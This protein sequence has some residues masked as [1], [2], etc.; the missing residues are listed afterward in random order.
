MPILIIIFIAGLILTLVIVIIQS[1]RTTSHIIDECGSDVDCP[2]GD[3]CLSNPEEQG[4]KQCFPSGK[5]FCVIDPPTQLKKCECSEVDENGNCVNGLA[6]CESCLNNPAFSCIQV[7]DKNPYT[8]IQGN[9]QVSIPNSATGYGWCLPNVVNRTVECNPFTS[10][11]ILAE[12]A[13]GQ[14]Q[15]GCY[16]KHENLFD[17]SQGP[18]SDC[19]LVKACRTSDGTVEDL[20]ALYVPEPV[21][22]NCKSDSQCGIGSKCLSPQNPP[23]C[24][25]SS[26]HGS[27]INSDCSKDGS[28]CVC[29]SKWEGDLVKKVDPLTGQCVCN[30]GLD[31]QCVVR[32]SDYYELNCVQGVCGTFGTTDPSLCNK[33]QCY[34]PNGDGQCSCCNCNKGYVRC[35]D[36]IPI[37]NAG[38]ISYCQSVGPTCILDPC[39]TKDVPDGYYDPTLPGCVCPGENSIALEDESSAV[40]QI[41][42]NA[43]RGNGPCGNRGKCYVPKGAKSYTDALCCDCS[44]PFT[45]DDDPSCTCS[46]IL[47]NDEGDEKLG[48]GGNCYKN[49]ECC[50]GYC[51][52]SGTCKGPP[53]TNSPCGTPCNKRVICPD[54][55]T[56]CSAGQVCCEKDKGKYSC[57]PYSDGVCCDGGD[58]CCPGT[59]T[60]CD[61]GEG[62]CP[63]DHPK[64]DVANKACTKADGTDPIPWT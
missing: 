43:C 20:G 50:S 10:E 51:G 31:Y 63:M 46:G 35:P 59:F 40:G 57:C 30:K 33:N 56:T 25:Y 47:R 44:C 13:P 52:K 58:R 2:K 34:D 39:S 5:S 42:V 24:G 15:W 6:S 7:S 41:C 62:C 64:C 19:T 14:Y 16:C 28:N 53:L 29:H 61:G 4:K 60:C 12:T 55:V 21:T 37:G 49:E 26:S 36:D 22:R 23:P 8:W 17:H 1:L 3:S 18:L 38:L 45:N 11:Y 9:T 32:S 48:A 27:I 54:N